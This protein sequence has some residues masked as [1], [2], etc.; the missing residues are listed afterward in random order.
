MTRISL[1]SNALPLSAASQSHQY[2][3]KCGSKSKLRSGSYNKEIASHFGNF[4]QA[5]DINMSVRRLSVG[6]QFDQAE[7]DTINM[8]D[9]GNRGV[10]MLYA[11]INYCI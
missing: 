7:V 3:P 9:G 8:G 5:T 10:N 4:R 1:Q 6:Y 11:V 2:C